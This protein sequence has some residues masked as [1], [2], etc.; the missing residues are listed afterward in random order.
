M[1]KDRLPPNV[2]PTLP[3]VK[4]MNP[5]LKYLLALLINKIFPKINS[6]APAWL[7]NLEAA[8]IFQFSS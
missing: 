1:N 2:N 4:T 3:V 7:K 6:T 5:C 8:E